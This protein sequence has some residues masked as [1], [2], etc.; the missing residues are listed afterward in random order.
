MASARIRRVAA[1]LAVTTALGFLP[2]SLEAAPL[3]RRGEVPT[4]VGRT[5]E[6]G[7]VQSLWSLLTSFWAK[8][9][10]KIDG[11]G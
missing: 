3:N 2:A 10:A 5:P 9:G 6:R 4:L 11:N 7:F 8:A 1:A